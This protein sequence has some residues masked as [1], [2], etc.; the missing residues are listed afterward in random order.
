[1]SN[2]SASYVLN[3][4]LPV[5]MLWCHCNIC[6]CHKGGNWWISCI[7]VI[8]LQCCLKLSFLNTI[9]SL[10][11]S[12]SDN[13]VTL[14]EVW[15]NKWSICPERQKDESLKH[16]IKYI[17]QYPAAPKH[18][19]SILDKFTVLTSV[20]CKIR[21]DWL[22][23]KILIYWGVLLPLCNERKSCYQPHMTVV[24]STSV[25]RLLP[26]QN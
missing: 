9:N 11:P 8:L 7:I 25:D 14:C 18:N 22:Q 2:T 21:R 16:I 10:S 13:S 12:C 24:I 6:W 5:I 1:M 23:I 26:L 17:Y 20:H 3:I 15:H 19:I 4:Y